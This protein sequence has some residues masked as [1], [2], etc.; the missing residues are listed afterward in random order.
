MCSSSLEALLAPAVEMG[1]TGAGRARLAAQTFAGAA[2]LAQ[3][4]ADAPAEL[5][6]QSHVEGRHDPRGDHDLSASA[7]TRPSSRARRARSRA[8]LGAVGWRARAAQG[9][10][11]S[12]SPLRAPA[13]SALP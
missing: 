7:S 6:E 1:L 2:A 13:R 12:A 9:G 10:G 4:S 3:G 11:S 8:E 5:R